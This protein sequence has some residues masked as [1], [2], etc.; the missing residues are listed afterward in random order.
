MSHVTNPS[1]SSHWSHNLL[2]AMNDPK[3]KVGED[4]LVVVLKDKY[5]KARHHIL[6]LPKKNIESINHVNIDDLN[7]LY[8]M[9]SIGKKFTSFYNEYEFK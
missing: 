4:H 8:H 5:P 2:H 7:L 6:I 9:E 3:A 1:D